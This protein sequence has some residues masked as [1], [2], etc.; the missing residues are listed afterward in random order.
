MAMRYE[1][2]AS[3]LGR[4]ALMLSQDR[5]ELMHVAE[6]LR[7]ERRDDVAELQVRVA[8]RAAAPERPEEDRAD[9]RPLPSQ[10]NH[11]DR[12]HV[13]R[14]RACPHALE[15]RIRHGVGNEHRLARRR[16]RA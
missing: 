12:P 14:F 9:H 3:L 11:D 4:R 5:L 16:R 8:E 1:L 13:A 6:R 10:G 7:R 15:R 2:D